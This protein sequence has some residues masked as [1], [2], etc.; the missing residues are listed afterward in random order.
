[1]K[2]PGQDTQYWSASAIFEAPCPQCKAV[3]EFFKDDPSRKCPHCG[4]RFVNPKMDFGCA[5]YCAYA[6]QCL[7]DLP[8]EVVAQKEDLLKDRVAVSV[9]S[10][11]KKDFKSIG[12][13]TRRARYAQA[14]GQEQPANMAVMLIAAYL[15]D[16]VDGNG[17]ARSILEH[18]K[19]PPKLID[20]VEEVVRRGVDASS[21]DA[22][23]ESSIAAD[24]AAIALL[25]E[26]VK[27]AALD[28]GP[29]A[30]AIERECRTSAGRDYARRL[31][32]E[33]LR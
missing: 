22:S 18:L 10:Y 19:A 24:A 11:F 25:E 8:P 6:E 7:G 3:V 27:D 17:A 28:G 26:R 33:S 13:A 16:L 29:L 12:R 5:A 23:P 14:L 9:K 1:M 32:A 2:C 30:E 4:H 15:W 20:R 21:P 31:F